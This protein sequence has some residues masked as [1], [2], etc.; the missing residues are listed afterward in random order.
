MYAS[1]WGVAFEAQLPPDCPN[2]PSFPDATLEA[3]DFYFHRTQFV[4]SAR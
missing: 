2:Q 3:G 1:N 4:L